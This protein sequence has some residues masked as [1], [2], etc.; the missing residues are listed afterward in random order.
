MGEERLRLEG[1]L[2]TALRSV[3][4]ELRIAFVVG[5]VGFL[6]T[7]YALRLFI[8]PE[9]EGQLL[10]TK[11]VVVAVTPFDV[12][13]LQAK[14]GLFA[15]LLFAGGWILYRS[16]ERFE[17][18]GVSL[19]GRRKTHFLVGI[20]AIA[21]FAG[22]VVYAYFVFLPLLFGF[23]ISNAIMAGFQP[24]Y[25]IVDWTQFV[26]LLVFVLG[27]TAELPL[28]MG[29]VVYADIVS[30]DLFREYWRHAVFAIVV[31]SSMVNGSPD[32]FSMSLVAIPMTALYFVGL[33]TAKVVGRASGN[34]SSQGRRSQSAV[35]AEIDL[36]DL[37]A[38]GIRTAPPEAFATLSEHEALELADDALDAGDSKKAEAILDRFD[39]RDE[40]SGLA[41]NEEQNGE[42][43]GGNENPNVSGTVE[44]TAGR[45]AAAFAEEE[46]T[47]DDIGGYYY[48]LRFV[49]G[50]L[51]SKSFRIIGV[52]MAV[53]ALVFTY[54][55]RGGIGA[56]KR[57]FLI[58]LPPGTPT[59]EVNIVLL[60]PVEALAFEM[61]VSLLVG[62][63]AVLPLMLYYAWP[64]IETRELARANRNVFFVWA[65]VLALGLLGGSFV[66]YRFVAPNV[67]SYLVADALAADM[68]IAYRT[69]AFFWLV[70]ATTVGVGLWI[71]VP[72]TMLLFH[73]GGVVR[74]RTMRTYWRQVAVG[75]LVVS[76]LLP[77]GVLLMVSVGFAVMLAYWVGLGAL[78]VDSLGE[79]LVRATT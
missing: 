52:F 17:A 5:V 79:R 47:E 55:Y 30:P 43:E 32:P 45:M 71:E 72:V 16:R 76:S 42:K 19:P 39:E 46:T 74:Y 77:G 4:S 63:V 58:H 75:V 3:R 27:L 15:G 2:G 34:P 12:V 41:A 64:A 26:F 1:V 60:H 11:A 53:V 65:G 21:L 66:G 40:S 14:I 69:A 37:D 67:M 44:R 9:L 68:I 33:G 57:D 25:S 24:T 29:G 50:S 49:V 35:P 51:R 18:R 6:A 28:I 10:G 7:F 31:I 56:I 70:F 36:S 78:W 22:G 73:H 23:L 20:L 62:A 61:K 13:L 54:L 8:W 48:D 59:S 38:K